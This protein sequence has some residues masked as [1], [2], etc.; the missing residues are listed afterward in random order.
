MQHAPRAL[1]LGL[2]TIDLQYLVDP[3]PLPNTKSKALDF[4]MAVGGPAVNAA[5][6]FVHLGGKARVFSVV[7]TH[8]MTAF[9]Q[10]DFVNHKL[11]LVDL[12]PDHPHLPTL[13]TVLTDSGNGD[14]TIVTSPRQPAALQLDRLE[15]QLDPAVRLILVDGFYMEAAIRLAAWGRTRGIP[16]VLDGGSWKLG[17]EDLLDF[18]DVAICSADFRVPDT[19]QP[20]FSWLRNKGLCFGAVTNG[21]EAIRFFENGREGILPVA[22]VNVVD[23]L[24]AGDVFHGAFCYYF[25]EGE[26]FET[27]LH[28]ASA[29][30]GRSCGYLGA[31]RW[32]RGEA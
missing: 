17:M 11:E 12:C 9:V 23:T 20:L 31:K 6:T 26:N 15:R 29:I 1:F 13:A 21:A 32:M 30:A 7:G 16:V 4:I 24:G 27:S 3:Y 10:E 19:D 22:A 2:T 25:A 8:P 5:A 14:R 18:V 28:L